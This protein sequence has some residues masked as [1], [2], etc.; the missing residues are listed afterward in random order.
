MTTNL[1]RVLAF[2]AAFACAGNS[3]AVTVSIDTSAARAVLKAIED[4]DLTLEQ[5]TRIAGMPGNKGAIRKLREFRIDA[6]ASAF[7][8]ALVAAAHGKT[9]TKPEE[10]AFLFDMLKPKVKQ[11]DELVTR[12]DAEPHDFQSS[13]QK[14]IAM[15]TPAGADMKLTGYV[16]AA[17]DGGGYAF[18]STDFY[19]NLIMTD[20]L[21]LARNVTTHEM[22]HAV[23]GAYAKER[24][25]PP[26]RAE[27]DTSPESACASSARLLANLYEEGTAVEVSDLSVLADAQSPSALRIRTDMADGLK[28]MNSSAYLMEMS[29]AS[30]NAARPVPY[31]E[32]YNVGFFGHSILYNVA[33]AMAKAIDDVDGPTGLAALVTQPAYKFF[34]RYTALPLYGKDAM[35]PRIG[36]NTAA[37]VALVAGGCE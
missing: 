4:P 20:E 6:T 34:Q 21:A 26:D 30:L 37:A 18:G 22:Y 17:G 13:I 3:L 27:G 5:A 2:A 29:F 32:V 14:R 33:Y 16:V 23:Q 10:V 1:L 24:Q 19:L 35:H 7:A 36:A 11:L 15:F 9:V 28:H 25:A 12:I 8:N 31:D